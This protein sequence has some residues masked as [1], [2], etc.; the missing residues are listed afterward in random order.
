[1]KGR[2]GYVGPRPD[3][4]SLWEVVNQPIIEGDSVPAEGSWSNLW[5]P[6]IARGANQFGQKMMDGGSWTNPLTWPGFLAG[7][8]VEALSK[9][10][11]NYVEGEDVSGLDAAMAAIEAVP[12]AKLATQAGKN[13]IGTSAVGQALTKK[14]RSFEDFH[15]RGDWYRGNKAPHLAGMAWDTLRDIS[16]RIVDPEAAALF[17]KHGISPT[18]AREFQQYFNQLDDPFIKTGN[19]K[20][21]SATPNEINSEAEYTAAMFEKYFPGNKAFAKDM[22]NH[23]LPKITNTTGV[24]MAMSGIPLSKVLDTPMSNQALAAHVSGPMVKEFGLD[25]KNVVLATKPWNDSPL[26]RLTTLSNQKGSRVQGLSYKYHGIGGK[27]NPSATALMLYKK[28]DGPFTMDSLEATA[29]KHNSDSLDALLRKEKSALAA[30]KGK[31]L[32][33]TMSSALRNKHFTQDPLVNIDELMNSAISSDGYI[34]FGGRI[35]GQ[36]RTFAHYNTRFVVKPGA[37]P[38]AQ[39]FV[40]DEFRQGTGVPVID[41]TLNAGS[42]EFIGIDV[43]PVTKGDGVLSSSPSQASGGLG[44]QE[45]AQLTREAIER[46]MAYESTLKDRAVHAAKVGTAMTGIGNI[47]GDE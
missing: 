47:W 44:G 26:E 6:D 10:F 17:K 41:N 34:S 1:M 11:K 43:V 46:K 5:G 3:Q 21:S 29:K 18:K 36:D 32:T 13:F 39:L 27:Y 19:T 40:Y 23:L 15:P 38:D 42:D 28:M 9:P 12:M 14:A 37:K 22:G 24:D 16:Q 7:A 8:S 33:K 31:P 2:P 45:R 20:K 25:G 35:L 30:R 4:P